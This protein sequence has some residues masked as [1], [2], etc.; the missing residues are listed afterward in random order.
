[1]NVGALFVPLGVIVCECVPSAEPVNVGAET[2][3]AGVPADFASDN[4]VAALVALAVGA[5]DIDSRAREVPVPK[6]EDASMPSWPVPPAVFWN[7]SSWAWVPSAEPVNI[8]AL[9]VPAGVP[10]LTALVD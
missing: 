8:G 1:M 5:A 3:P 2:V 9:F 4:S 10:A 7:G 6:I